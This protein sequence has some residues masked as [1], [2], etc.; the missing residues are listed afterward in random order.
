[1]HSL[2]ISF[3]LIYFLIVNI[4]SQSQDN[5]IEIAK[6]LKPMLNSSI[7]STYMFSLEPFLLIKLYNAQTFVKQDPSYYINYQNSTLRFD[8]VNATIIFDISIIHNNPLSTGHSSDSNINI[9]RKNV[10][11]FVY[12]KYVI[13][14]Q[15]TDNS[16]V[17][18]P[19]PDDK[20]NV[21]F[22][23]GELE[24]FSIYE[25]FNLGES[26]V[27]K[28]SFAVLFK[29]LLHEVLYRYPKSF[30]TIYFEE[31]INYMNKVEYFPTDIP[32]VDKASITQITYER[33]EKIDEITAK[34]VNVDFIATYS[35]DGGKYGPSCRFE[36]IFLIYGTSFFNFGSF[37]TTGPHLFIENFS[38]NI[39]NKVL[40]IVLEK[41]KKTR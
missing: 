17:L 15:L 19:L 4:K 31:T 9:T 11:A 25:H 37:Y 36:E 35:A 3:V 21:Q 10:F 16:L 41:Y 14:K 29:D 5:L 33:M 30:L 26:E 34:F 20:D 32:E 8:K 39:F 27:F 1:M 22:N 24:L 18:E 38:Q 23:L 12:Y 2:Q 7:E 6:K 40:G 28:R 13:F